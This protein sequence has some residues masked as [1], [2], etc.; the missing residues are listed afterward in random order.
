[1]TIDLSRNLWTCYIFGE[2]SKNASVL[3][4]IV[5]LIPNAFLHLYVM[6][7]TRQLVKVFITQAK[8]EFH[9]KHKN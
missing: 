8:A 9:H 1:M 4:A 5:S 3:L 6:K 2:S 7:I